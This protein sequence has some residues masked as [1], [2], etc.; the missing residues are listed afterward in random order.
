[1]SIRGVDVANWQGDIGW[2]AVAGSGVEFAMI[3]ATEGLHF[4]DPYFAANWQ[5]AGAAGLCRGAYHFMR[6]D[7][8]SDPTEE[9]DFLLDAVPLESGDCLALDAEDYP[10]R[11]Q[12]ADLLWWVSAFLAHVAG[13]VGFLPFLYSTTGYL[14][15]HNLLGSATLSASGLWLASWFENPPAAFPPAPPHWP[16][17]AVWQYTDHASVPGIAGGVDGDRFN[18]PADQMRAYGFGG[19]A[20]QAPPREPLDALWAAEEACLPVYTSGPDGRD[21]EAIR[22]RIVSIKERYGYP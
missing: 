19:G 16:F 4:V 20:A 17:V 9:A 2:D 14:A 11:P 3:K 7:L 15:A 8:G 5:G 10:G 18:G 22:Y 13:R 12:P 21:L 1:M 6:A